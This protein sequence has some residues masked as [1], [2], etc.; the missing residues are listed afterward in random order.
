M[1][2]E[3]Y[4]FWRRF[5]GQVVSTGLRQF[6]DAYTML[7][8]DLETSDRDYVERALGSKDK[9]NREITVFG[10]I[11]FTN[12]HGFPFQQNI[13][14]NGPELESLMSEER[15]MD[16][17]RMVME[18]VA[19]FSSQEMRNHLINVYTWFDGYKSKQERRARANEWG[20]LEAENIDLARRALYFFYQ[21]F[22]VMWRVGKV[23][24]ET[25]SGVDF[26]GK[27]RI[28]DFMNLI[29]PLDRANFYIVM[30]KE[31]C[32]WDERKPKV[33]KFLDQYL[34]LTEKDKEKEHQSSQASIEMPGR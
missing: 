8:G 5:F 20:R 17:T 25:L 27:G 2:D 18:L 16:L 29:G 14:S 26:P 9:A 12:K 21:R 33:Y 6:I 1:A 13:A 28:K 3:A 10:F 24:R 19:D 32:E 7:Y 31:D 30:G 23:S 34:K 4:M 22:M 15:I 11:N